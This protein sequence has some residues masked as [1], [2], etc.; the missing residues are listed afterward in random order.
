MVGHIPKQT[1]KPRDEVMSQLTDEEQAQLQAFVE[2]YRNSVALQGKV[3]AFQ[4]ADIAQAAMRAVDSLSERER[5]V[6]LANLSQAAQ[7]IR[8]FLARKTAA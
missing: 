3:Y 4:F 6:V 8:R 5:E 7:E 2:N 1:L